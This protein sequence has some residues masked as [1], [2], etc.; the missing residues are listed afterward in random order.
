MIAVFLDIDHFI[1]VTRGSLHNIFV[2]L[3]LPIILFIL[4]LKLEKKGDYYK[5]VSLV[6]LL[7]L[8][9]HPILDMFTEEGV[10]LFY[11]F[12]TQ[13]YDLSYLSLTIVLPSGIQAYVIS[14]AGVGLTIYFLMVLSAIFVEDFLKVL[15][16]E[17]KLEKALVKTM[18]EEEKK[19]E[20]EL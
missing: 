8:F 4:A 15:K 10:V 18:E 2:T 6:L 16:R 19:I 20:K 3:L 7:F 11:P 17:R 1:G 14:T 13:F 9:S 12:S 5:N